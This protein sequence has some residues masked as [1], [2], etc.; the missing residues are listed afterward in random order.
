MNFVT[1]PHCNGR[2]ELVKGDFIYK[3]RPDLAELNFWMCKPCDAYVGCHRNGSRTV[4]LGRLANAE[5]RKW[6][7]MAHAKFDPLW[8]SGRMSRKGAYGW[9]ANKLGIGVNECHISWFGADQCKR[10]VDVCATH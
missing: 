5:E 4:P 7:Q 1:C 3:Q 2:A 9:L 6:R 8:R 10:V